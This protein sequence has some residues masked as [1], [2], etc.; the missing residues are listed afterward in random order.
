MPEVSRLLWLLLLELTARTNGFDDSC[1][2]LELHM[3]TRKR[4]CAV[5][6]RWLSLA[7]GFLITV[8]ILTHVPQ[9]KVPVDLTRLSVDKAIHTMAYGALTFLFLLAFGLPV[10]PLVPLVIVVFILA[11]AALD[12]WTQGFVGRR[13][14]QADFCADGV[15]A[16]LAIVLSLVLNRRRKEVSPLTNA[17]GR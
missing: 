2:A 15:G 5:Q 8:L 16:V 1:F 14:S 13:A 12:E 7:F 3:N 10:R 9:R 6:W 11:V 17:D 4:N